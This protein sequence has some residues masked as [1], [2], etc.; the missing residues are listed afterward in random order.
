M[1][2]RNWRQ[3]ILFVSRI[4]CTFPR[5]DQSD[6]ATGRTKGTKRRAMARNSSR[7]T[8]ADRRA[9]GETRAGA[10]AA[11]RRS[12]GDDDVYHAIH[13]AILDHRLPPGTRLAEIALAGLFGTTRTVVR[14]ALARLE[15]EQLVELRAN[16]GAVVASPSIDESR[17]LFAARRAIECAIVQS[18]S[19]SITRAQAREL[20]ALVRQEVSAYRRGEMRQGLKLSIA[21]HRTIAAMAGNTVLAQFL[22]QLV[23]RT[24]LVVLAYRGPDGHAACTDDEHSAIAEAI[25]SG[26]GDRASRLMS[27]HLDAIASQLRLVDEDPATD[28]ATIFADRRN[29]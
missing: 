21:F 23:A 29:R 15:H 4:L 1:T 16:R 22:D 12:S 2:R 5:N 8:V 26:A 9:P 14:K 7:D 19:R 13:G 27:T 17:H 28:L 18:L 25:A 24:P 3:S 10:S 20:R 6:E 11:P